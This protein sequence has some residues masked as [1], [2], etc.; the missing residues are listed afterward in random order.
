[1]HKSVHR[2]TDRQT[3]THIHTQTH[4]LSLSFSLPVSILLT[5]FIKQKLPNSLSERV[6][7]KIKQFNLVQILMCVCVCVCLCVC[8]FVHV[9]L[10]C[11]HSVFYVI[12]KTYSKTTH[13]WYGMEQAVVARRIER[14]DLHW[15]LC[16]SVRSSIITVK[17]SLS[18]HGDR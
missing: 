3:R 11:L 12:A 4:T 15:L 13:C 2:Q 1:M 14:G 16:S 9:S 17:S 6:K 10:V 7:F 5:L 8:M 18:T